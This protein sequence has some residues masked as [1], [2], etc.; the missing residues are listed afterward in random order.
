MQGEPCMSGLIS[1]PQTHGGPT[2]QQVPRGAL[3]RSS[4]RAG[5]KSVPFTTVPSMAAP[6]L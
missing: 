5:D 6:G 1:A 4:L 3:N 2:G